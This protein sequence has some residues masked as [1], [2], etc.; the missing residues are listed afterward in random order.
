MSSFN[1]YVELRQT[2]IKRKQRLIAFVSTGLFLGS[3]V[4]AVGGFF[5]DTFRQITQPKTSSIIVQSQPM[6]EEKGYE[7]V[8]Q[9]EPENQMALESLVRT[10][11]KRGDLEGA[12]EPLKK[13]IKL[14][15]NNATYKALLV[16]VKKKVGD[17]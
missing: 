12:Q 17:R 15:P 6:M 7:L 5:A 8:L 14:N 2:Q 11:I 13:L 16:Q 4:F 10:R 9:R 3:T 1:D